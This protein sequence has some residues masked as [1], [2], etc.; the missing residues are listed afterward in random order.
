MRSTKQII[1]GSQWNYYNWEYCTLRGKLGPGAQLSGAQLS[2]AQFS[3]NPPEAVQLLLLRVLERQCSAATIGVLWSQCSTAGHHHPRHMGAALTAQP[4]SRSNT[5]YRAHGGEW[6]SNSSLWWTAFLGNKSFGIENT[7]PGLG[8]SPNSRVILL[9]APLTTLWEV[10]HRMVST[11]QHGD[12]PLTYFFLVNS[13]LSASWPRTHH[14]LH[15]DSEHTI[16]LITIFTRRS[17]S[18]LG[19]SQHC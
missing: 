9:T 17:S 19:L 10:W 15:R 1:G 2:E 11:Y 5:A 8:K 13:S 3:V 7:P 14:N 16:I 6:W 18:C 4:F 12:H